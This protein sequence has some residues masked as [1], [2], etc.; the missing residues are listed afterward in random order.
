MEY[1]VA[2]SYANATIVNIDEVEKKAIIEMTCDRCGGTGYYALGTHNGQPVLSPYDGG[3]CYGCG[4]SGKIR[5]RVKAYTPDEYEKYL[6]SQTRAKERKAEKRAAEVAKLQEE[7]EANLRIALKEAGYE[8]EHPQ[9]WLV[10]GENTYAI[11]DELKELSCKYKPEFGWYCTHPVDVPANYG[12]VGIPFDEVCEWNPLAKKILIKGCAKEIADAAKN[13]AMPK[14][15]SE[16]IGEIKQRLR[17]LHVML[18]GCRTVESYYGVSLVYTFKMGDNVLTWFCSGKGIDPDIEVGDAVLLT[19]TVKDHKKYNGVK[20]TY[21]NRCI[22]K[23]E[24]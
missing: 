7:S 6:A 13:E 17:D 16:Y 8:I 1:R 19:G 5:K 3:V 14:S 22:V 2:P 4:G 9:V 11:K 23:R 10:T 15:N 21:L 18:T 12:M 24:D 20:Q